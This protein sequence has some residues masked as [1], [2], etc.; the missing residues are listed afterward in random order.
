MVATRTG[1]DPLTVTVRVQWADA[2]TRSIAQEADAVTKLHA[3]GLLP[4]SYALKRLGYDEDDI[5][6][7]RIAREADSP[8]EPSNNQPTAS[9]IR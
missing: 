4:A 5:K 7:I 2:S 8:A 6:A 3:A 9:G 1:V